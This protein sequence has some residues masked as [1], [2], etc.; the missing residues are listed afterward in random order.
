MRIAAIIGACLL[1]STTIHASGPELEIKAVDPSYSNA[2][3]EYRRIWSES[4]SSIVSELERATGASLDGQEIEVLVFEGMS[5]SGDASEPMKL[6]ASYAG[7]VKRATLVHELGHRYLDA[8][9]I[10]PDCVAEVHDALALVLRDVWA[11]LWGEEF[12]SEQ[13]M[14][15][16]E[17]NERY[18]RSWAKVLSLS[19]K[20]RRAW[21]VDFWSSCRRPPIHAFKPTAFESTLS[22]DNSF[23][24]T[25]GRQCGKLTRRRTPFDS[26]VVARSRANRLWPK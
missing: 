4:G 15:E 19:A 24:R 14:V 5:S 16:S 3:V 23:E 12:A 1:C 20:E 2:A 6:R 18:R 17:R 25:K 26:V 11:N 13:A 22:P 8:A 10:G 7:D 9:G 21:V